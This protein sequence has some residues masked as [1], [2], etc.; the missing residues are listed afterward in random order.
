[1]TKVQGISYNSIGA[2]GTYIHM[3][4]PLLFWG[5]M[6]PLSRLLQDT[7]ERVRKIN[8]LQMRHRRK[9]IH[10]QKK[11]GI[12]Y[13][14]RKVELMAAYARGI[15]P[16]TEVFFKHK[17]GIFGNLVTN[18]SLPFRYRALFTD[19]KKREK[20][21]LS[22]YGAWV[23]L[24]LLNKLYVKH[25]IEFELTRKSYAL[26]HLIE[27]FFRKMGAN[28]L[29]KAIRV[30]FEMFFPIQQFTAYFVITFCI[31]K[32]KWDLVQSMF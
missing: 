11:T 19:A 27:D 30:D 25:T 28:Y 3:N 22:Y 17:T 26:T 20:R 6:I 13:L 21:S 14:G 24:R 5:P 4:V 2:E 15:D 32:F 7:R 16:F 18:K 9:P 8:R 23:W 10:K 12:L 29:L 1:M 31:K